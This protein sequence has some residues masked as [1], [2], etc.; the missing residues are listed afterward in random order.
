MLKAKNYALHLPN[1]V[2]GPCHEG[3]MADSFD[4][5]D[6]FKRVL[7]KAKKVHVQA[8]YSNRILK[9]QSS[10]G[11]SCSFLISS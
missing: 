4:S 1:T 9:I 7:L 3:G 11:S 2:L 8:G 10:K 6:A 5:L